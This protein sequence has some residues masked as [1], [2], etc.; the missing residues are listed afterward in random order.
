MPVQMRRAGKFGWTE[1]A[2]LR[3]R[4]LRDI[5]LVRTHARDAAV[6]LVLDHVGRWGRRRTRLWL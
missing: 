6:L 2:Q 3:L 4:Q 1:R 5:S